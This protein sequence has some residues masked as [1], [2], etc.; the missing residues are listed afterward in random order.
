[1]EVTLF[2]ITPRDLLAKIL[3]PIPTTLCTTGLK[4]L[5]PDREMLPPRDTTMIPLNW[6]LRPP[7][8]HFGLLTPLNQQAK[9]AV[10]M[11]AVVIGPDY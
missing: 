7:S 2:T 3:I 10:T 11:L 1:M 5:V 8:A 4:V 9:K 6:K